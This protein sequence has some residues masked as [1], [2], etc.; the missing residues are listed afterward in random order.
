MEDRTLLSLAVP[1]LVVMPV[2]VTPD[3][4]TQARAPFLSCQI[5]IAQCFTL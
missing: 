4:V 2:A 5:F 1:K 3:H